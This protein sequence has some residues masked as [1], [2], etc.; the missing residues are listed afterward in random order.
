MMD[1]TPA[2]LATMLAALRYYQQQGMCDEDNRPPE[3]EDIATDGGSVAAL[4]EDEV[5]DLCQQLNGD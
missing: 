4:D 1:F 2:Q 3:I 5:D